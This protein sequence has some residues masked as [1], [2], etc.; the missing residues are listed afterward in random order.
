MQVPDRFGGAARRVLG[1]RAPPATEP[2]TAA[3]GSL[4]VGGARPANF[5]RRDPE[6][7]L[8]FIRQRIERRRAAPPPTPSGAQAAL[9][10]EVAGHPWYH[11]IDLGD[12]IVTEG[13]YD[14]RP[15]LPF[16][17]IPDTLEGMRVL[18]V[19]SADGFWAFEFE[20]RGGDVTA[21]DIASTDDVDLPGRVRELARARGV[22]DPLRDG[23]RLARGVLESKVEVVTASVYEL[24]PSNLDPFDLVHSGD[25]LLHLRDPLR[26]LERIRSVTSGWALLSDVFDPS[27]GTNGDGAGLMRYGGGWNTAGW[28]VPS[29][30]SLQQLVIDAGFSGVEVLT[31]YNL[32]ARGTTEG[33][34]RAVL[35]ARP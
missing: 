1:R 4:I 6:L 9:A 19:A 18:D 30:A 35:R 8:Q 25:L 29:L 16:Y 13:V 33:P 17:G 7:G 32:A 26:A 22:S 2:Q 27:L 5:E 12:G 10:Q 34:W 24:S 31:T 15:L 28:W 14:H 20:R 11:T 3:G 21:L 23:L